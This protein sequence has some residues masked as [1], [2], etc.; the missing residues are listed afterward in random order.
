MKLAD[1]I[2]TLYFWLT[3]THFKQEKISRKGHTG[4]MN[5]EVAIFVWD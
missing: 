2:F 3:I 5:L 1:D 4:Q